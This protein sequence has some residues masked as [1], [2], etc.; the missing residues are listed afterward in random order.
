M[1]F[2]NSK[3]SGTL[4][5]VGGIQFVISL[6]IA[7]AIYPNYS[8]SANYISDLGVW[9]R[10]SAMVFN[11]SIMI[12]G[13]TVSAS[14]YFIQKMFKNRLITVLFALAGDGSFGVGIFSENTFIVNCIPIF[15][16]VSAILAFVFGG[17]SAVA[18]Y[19][20]TKPPFKYLSVI[21]AQRHSMQQFSLLQ[22]GTLDTWS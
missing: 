10:S 5:F 2:A 1:P 7:E 13:L 9:G 17:I 15:H 3:I 14:S 22:H 20:I 19:K 8:V 21:L 12:L 16:S 18:V 6:I 11:P 4:L